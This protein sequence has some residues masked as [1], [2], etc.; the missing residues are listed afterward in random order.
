MIGRSLEKVMKFNG[1]KLGVAA[2]ISVF[3]VACDSK[4]PGQ[5]EEVMKLR[6]ENRSLTEKLKIAGEQATSNV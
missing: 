3:L 1:L 6:E 2:S 4:D 5:A